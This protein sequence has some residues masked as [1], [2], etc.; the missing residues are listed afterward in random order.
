MIEK[1]TDRNIFPLLERGLQERKIELN[2]CLD[3]GCGMNPL[4]EWF[5][6]NAASAQ[7]QYY[8][9]DAHPA[10][11]EG[12]AQKGITVMTPWDVPANFSSDLVIAAEVIEHVPKDDIAKFVSSLNQWTG[13]VLALTCPN[14]ADFDVNR[15]LAK[16]KELRFV[17]DHLVDFNAQSTDPSFHKTET[18]PG[19]LLDAL[20]KGFPAP[21]WSVTVYKAWPWL[22]A[23]IPAGKSY[24]IYFKLFALVWRN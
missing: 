13:K 19:M 3:V 6:K 5:R 10:V 22:L 12:L 7:A 20:Q 9:I 18:T 2:S 24:L 21:E 4:D 8:A 1:T 16:N 11:K 15:K 14:F 17:P 23:D